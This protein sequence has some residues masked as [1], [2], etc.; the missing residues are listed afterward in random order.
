[1]GST[2]SVQPYC[3]LATEAMQTMPSTSCVHGLANMLVCEFG[4]VFI[5]APPQGGPADPARAGRG[6]VQMAGRL[7]GARRELTFAGTYRRSPCASWPWEIDRPNA[8]WNYESDFRLNP[9]RPYVIYL[10]P[11]NRNG[12]MQECSG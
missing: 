10:Q 4:L 11:V 6:N 12:L 9:G 1:M 5:D 2:N 8:L 3:M 7:Y